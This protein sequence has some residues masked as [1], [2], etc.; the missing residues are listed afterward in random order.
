MPPGQPFTIA[1]TSSLL[2]LAD[3]SGKALPQNEFQASFT[4]PAADPNYAPPSFM[5]HRTGPN[6][7]STVFRF[8]VTGPT[9]P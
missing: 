9:V 6:V 8:S 7:P 2:A 4:S 5:G 1:V 3:A